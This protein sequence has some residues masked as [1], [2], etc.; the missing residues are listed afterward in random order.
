[1]SLSNFQTPTARLVWRSTVVA[2]HLRSHLNCLKSL[3]PNSA[4]SQWR[5]SKRSAGRHLIPSENS[6][7]LVLRAACYVFLFGSTFLFDVAYA[8]SEANC[9]F[10]DPVRFLLNGVE[11]RVPAALQPAYSPEG[12]VPTRDYF[13]NGVRAKLYCQL[14]DDQPAAVQA[15]IFP[16]SQL[17]AWAASNSL[18][19]QLSNI[20]PL[21][22]GQTFIPPPRLSEGGDVTPDG[23]FRRIARGPRYEL[24]STGPLLFGSPITADGGP[25]GTQQPSLR[26]TIWGRLP[27][28]SLLTLGVLDTNKPR[29]S[30][31]EMLKHVERFIL[32]LNH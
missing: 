14:K 22:I 20:N 1:M 7:F 17:D 24:V 15:I 30:W 27:D 29:E 8:S 23:L 9:N 3:L 21:A 10:A 32:S 25:A 6:I 4:V 19:A 11:Y 28:G 31:P 5:D 12:A 16:K 2:D 13:P 26:C 18:F